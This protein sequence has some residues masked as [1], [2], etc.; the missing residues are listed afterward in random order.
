VEN[1]ETVESC[2]CDS[3]FRLQ[4]TAV[5]THSQEHVGTPS[6]SSVATATANAD[7]CESVTAKT[8]SQLEDEL[9]SLLSI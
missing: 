5:S 8:L 1:V 2:Q 4:S 3:D 7:C 9:D 6:S